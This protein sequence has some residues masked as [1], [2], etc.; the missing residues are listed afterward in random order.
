M[1][2]E[3]WKNR[4]HG[5]KHRQLDRSSPGQESA[6][7]RHCREKPCVFTLALPTPQWNG[8]L[9]LS[10]LPV[11]TPLSSGQSPMPNPPSDAFPLDEWFRNHKGHKQQLGGGFL[12]IQNTEWWFLWFCLEGWVQALGTCHYT[13]QSPY[14]QSPFPTST[15]T[16]DL[17]LTTPCLQIRRRR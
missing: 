14:S 6:W 1:W 4:G 11:L 7:E 16:H 13:T 15:A 10:S 9:F 12:K 3:K 8:I 5:G 2:E 17:K